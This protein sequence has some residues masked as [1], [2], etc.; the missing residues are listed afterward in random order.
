MKPTKLLQTFFAT[1]K[2]LLE[3]Y[4][5]AGIL[6]VRYAMLPLQGFLRHLIEVQGLDPNDTTNNKLLRELDAIFGSLQ[7]ASD[8]LPLSWVK[9]RWQQV[10][11]RFRNDDTVESDVDEQVKVLDLDAEEDKLNT[12]AIDLLSRDEERKQKLED[13]C[14]TADWRK[15]AMDVEGNDLDTKEG[16]QAYRA[17][18]AEEDALDFGEGADFFGASK[19]VWN[20]KQAQNL[21]RLVSS[22][23]VNVED[24]VRLGL[25]LKV[26]QIWKEKYGAK[27]APNALK[28]LSALE[29]MHNQVPEAKERMESGKGAFRR[30]PPLPPAKSF[31]EAMKNGLESRGS[32]KSQGD[33]FGVKPAK[34]SLHESD[35][36][37]M[38]P[39]S[40]EQFYLGEIRNDM[41]EFKDFGG[42]FS[43]SIEPG[44][45]FVSS[46]QKAVNDKF[47]RS[48]AL[49]A[50]MVE[51]GFCEND[52]T[53][54]DRQIDELMMV[55][56]PSFET[57]ER[58]IGR[59]EKGGK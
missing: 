54:I 38:P 15:K 25:S 28:V 7:S 23:K 33:I 45:K 1:N 35:S 49:V 43:R 18:V 46:K 29:T 36:S 37:T 6:G 51:F 16:R 13:L 48:E 24:L 22:G 40:Q 5:N 39:S 50:K 8:E 26:A 31:G 53:V 56:M 57:I 11:D 44:S 27:L 52:Q 41:P 34:S 12:D 59:H 10:N 19:S 42:C 3:T 32:F 2:P 9:K 47:A 17:K 4:V 14:G 21:L 30:L 20:E 58:V 55:D